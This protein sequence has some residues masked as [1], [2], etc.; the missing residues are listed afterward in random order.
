MRQE[1]FGEREREREHEEDLI[2]GAATLLLHRY[3]ST[4]LLALTYTTQLCSDA[5]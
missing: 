3:V 2:L 1:K 5:H 4:C